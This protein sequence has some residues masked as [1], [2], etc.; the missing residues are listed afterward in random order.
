MHEREQNILHG[1]GPSNTNLDVSLFAPVMFAV[2][3][4]MVEQTPFDS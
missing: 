2:F 4:T 1:R 3:L